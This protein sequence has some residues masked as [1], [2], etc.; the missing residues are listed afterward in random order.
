M[1]V[2]GAAA[3]DGA[4]GRMFVVTLVLNVADAI[5]H[6]ATDQ[7][8]VL[9]ILSNLLLIVTSAVLIYRPP[10]ERATTCLTAAGLYFALNALSI[11]TQGIGPLGIMLIAAST[12]LMSLAALLRRIT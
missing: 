7:V 4:I 5:L 11:V 1:T 10:W 3:R 8:E 6:V 2:G 9:R 12:L